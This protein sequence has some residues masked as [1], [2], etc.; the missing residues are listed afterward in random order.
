MNITESQLETV[1]PR[2]E[3]C[4]ILVVAGKFRG[5]VGRLLH[6]SKNSDYAAVELLDEADVQKLHF[7]D[8]AEYTGSL[9]CF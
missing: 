7:D 9:D 2:N 6:R 3:G 8:I 5:K 1:V 4:P